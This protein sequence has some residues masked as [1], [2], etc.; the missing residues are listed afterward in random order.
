LVDPEVLVEV[1]MFQTLPQSE[2]KRLAAMMREEN[3]PAGRILFEVGDPGSSM[4]IIRSGKIRIS[5][6]GDSG[7]EV[8][9]ATLAAGDFF[10]E[11]ALLDQNPR[12]ARATAV[13]VA[14]LYSLDREQFL[15]FVGSRPDAAL[16]M[17]SATA[18][19]LRHTDELM[20][21]R[22]SFDVN[23]EFKRHETRGARWA[24]RLADL[25]GSWGF[26]TVYLVIVTLW[27]GANILTRRLGGAAFDSEMYELLGLALGIVASFQAP[28]IM[29][30]Q[31]R[32]Q[33]RDRIQADADFKVNLKNE[34]AIEKAVERIDEMRRQIPELKRQIKEHELVIKKSHDQLRKAILRAGAHAAHEGAP[35][36]SGSEAGSGTARLDFGATVTTPLPG[37]LPPDDEEVVGEGTAIYMPGDLKAGDSSGER[38][39]AGSG[40]QRAVGDRSASTPPGNPGAASLEAPSAPPVEPAGSGTSTMN[41]M[42]VR[43]LRIG[44]V[45]LGTVNGAE[46]AGSEDDTPDPDGEETAR[47][48]AGAAGPVPAGSASTAGA[49]TAGSDTLKGS[50]A[51]ALRAFRPTGS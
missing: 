17:L 6:P 30:S 22:A 11:L 38:K 29:M 41:A 14:Q 43:D 35:A 8:S 48:D 34:V 4:Y 23:E 50:V 9:L 32:D 51:D 36:G 46:D 2:R 39:A 12:S 26:I 10:G 15:S 27:I 7:E 24:A 45:R 33:L 25:A 42:F 31:N 19:R 44:P 18:K 21:S 16:S 13:D 49:K 20:R 40:R 47:T 1:P 28:I 3:L 37:P 5:I